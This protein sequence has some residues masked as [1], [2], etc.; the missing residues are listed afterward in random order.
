MP[1]KKKMIRP[2]KSNK[3]KIESNICK[4]NSRKNYENKLCKPKELGGT[5]L[6]PVEKEV[7]N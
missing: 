1:I 3:C 6:M 2:D 5:N 4:K 7:R